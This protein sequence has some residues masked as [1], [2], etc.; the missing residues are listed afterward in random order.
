MPAHQSNYL[1]AYTMFK[2]IDLNEFRAEFQSMGR[3]GQ[4]SYD[5]LGVLFDYLEELEHCEEPYE[6]DV[7]ALCCDFAE[8]DALEV[9]ND[10]SIDLGDEAVCPENVQAIV[11]EY[12]EE[13]TTL[14]GETDDGRFVYHQF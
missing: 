4:F 9:A 5:G 13:N 3:G 8:G 14:V 6:L 10:Y 7:I 11:R 2:R 12:L 1:R